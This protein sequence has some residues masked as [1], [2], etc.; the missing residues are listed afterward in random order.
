[1]FDAVTRFPNDIHVVVRLPGCEVTENPF[2][3]SWRYIVTAN[4][5]KDC[6]GKSTGSETT[7]APFGIEK[8]VFPLKVSD[9]RVFVSMALAPGA[10]SSGSAIVAAVISRLFT[11]NT[12]EN[13]T[14]IWVPPTDMCSVCRRV[15]FTKTA[16]DPF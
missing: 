12:F 7:R 9:F 11:P 15:E 3:P 2:C 10:P 14:R 5:D 1:M 13:R 8:L 4:V 6:I 16:A